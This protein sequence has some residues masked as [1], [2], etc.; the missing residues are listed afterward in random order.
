M[1]LVL[2]LGKRKQRILQTLL[3]FTLV[4]ELRAPFFL[5]SSTEDPL[6]GDQ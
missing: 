6:G 5:I 4:A 1:T 2:H 3:P